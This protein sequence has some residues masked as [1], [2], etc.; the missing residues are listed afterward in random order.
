MLHFYMK[1]Q[2]LINLVRVNACSVSSSPVDLRST[3]LSINGSVPEV[4]DEAEGADAE[5][6]ED[7]DDDGRGDSGALGVVHRLSCGH[8]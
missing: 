6:Q 2:R 4:H 5:R 7:G 1:V 3:S 8:S